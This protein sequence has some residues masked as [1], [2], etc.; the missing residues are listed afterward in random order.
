MCLVWKFYLPLHGK[1]N[2]VATTPSALATRGRRGA[3]TYAGTRWV[4]SKSNIACPGGVT[5]VPS[6]LLALITGAIDRHDRRCFRYHRLHQR[7]QLSVGWVVET[8]R[9]LRPKRKCDVSHRSRLRFSNEGLSVFDQHCQ[10]FF[11][12]FFAGFVE[13]FLRFLARDV[14]GAGCGEGWVL[15]L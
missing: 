13:V 3:P 5:A 11:C 12:E 14:G 6:N 15:G 8:L 1:A 4:A 2:A 9:P 7:P 10:S